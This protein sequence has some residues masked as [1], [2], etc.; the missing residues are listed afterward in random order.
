M[1]PF[2][3]RKAPVMPRWRG[4]LRRARQRRLLGAVVAGRAGRAQKRLS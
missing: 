2:P 1:L 3:R 4:L